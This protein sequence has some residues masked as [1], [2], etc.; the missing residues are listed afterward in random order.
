MKEIIGII[1]LGA[2]AIFFISI[3]RMVI[4]WVYKSIKKDLKN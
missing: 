1:L 4:Y 2:V 3:M